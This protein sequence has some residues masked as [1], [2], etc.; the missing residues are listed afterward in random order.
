MQQ[1]SII[2]NI[3]V[4]VC[5][6]KQSS[7]NLADVFCIK[8]PIYLIT[9]KYKSRSAFWHYLLMKSANYSISLK[10]VSYDIKYFVIFRWKDYLKVL[11]FYLLIMTICWKKEIILLKGG[12]YSRKYSKH[13]WSQELAI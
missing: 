10:I 1:Q 7:L 13:W 3:V 11:K 5:S 6:I 9:Q 2:V 8:I 12:H 4:V